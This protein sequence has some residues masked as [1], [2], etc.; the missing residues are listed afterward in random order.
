MNQT[1]ATQPSSRNILVW[2]LP[3]RAF[4]WSL[5][6]CFAVAYLTA[7][8]E[9]L[10]L[11]HQLAGYLFAA[12]ITFRLVWGV[13][14][15]RYARFTEF[16][17]SPAEVIRYAASYLKRAPQ[18]YIGHNPL[19]ALAIVLMLALGIGIVA[20]GWLNVSGGE[21]F[22]EVHE[23]FANAMLV[24]VI[25]HIGGVIASSILH[26]ENLARAMVTGI[27]QGPSEAGIRRKHGIIALLLVAALACLSWS[28][29]QGK[30][31]ALMDP[32]AISTAQGGHGE[33]DDDD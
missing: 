14:G 1:L 31:P 28:L 22:E 3:T 9:A 32:T 16:L 18:H 2:D 30:L 27:K 25:A 10:A 19:G 20:T 21:A 23:F 5:A 6:G 26:R 13:F 24:V 7:E 11:I 29:S 12:L 4:H 33:G 8:S 17:R 15:S